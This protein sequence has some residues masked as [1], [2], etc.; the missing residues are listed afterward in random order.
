SRR[1]VAF[2]PLFQFTWLSIRGLSNTL[3]HMSI[4]RKKPK[5]NHRCERYKRH[6]GNNGNKRQT[7]AENE[8]KLENW[9]ARKHSDSNVM[10]MRKSRDFG[11]SISTAS[12]FYTF[13]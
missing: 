4:K 9:N 13:V 12:L 8:Q 10:Q 3:Q 6:A 7:Q 1:R 11:L 2:H 5:T